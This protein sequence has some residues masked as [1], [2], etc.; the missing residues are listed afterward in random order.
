MQTLYI[1]K[2]CLSKGIR[3]ITGGQSPCKN[4]SIN[5]WHLGEDGWKRYINCK[6]GEVF[7]T[8]EAAKEAAIAYRAAEVKR[9]RKRIDVLMCLDFEDGDKDG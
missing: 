5:V 9:L 2:N 6:A 8:Y 3:K 1:T 7:E 4:G